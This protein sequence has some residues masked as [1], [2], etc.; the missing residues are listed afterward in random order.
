MTSQPFS[1]IF[2]VRLHRLL[3]FLPLL[4]VLFYLLPFV[5]ANPSNGIASS[6]TM[7][8]VVSYLNTGCQNALLL[9]LLL[10]LTAI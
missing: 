4:Y 7:A 9:L 8:G 2:S 1:L 3:P 5:P 6:S 10:L